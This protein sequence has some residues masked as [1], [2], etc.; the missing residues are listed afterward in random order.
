L[1]SPP[2]NGKQ[3]PKPE[4]M[5][6]TDSAVYKKEFSFLSDQEFSSFL[7]TVHI[8]DEL[9]EFLKSNKN[10]AWF[11]H[12]QYL[13]KRSLDPHSDIDADPV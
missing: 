8:A 7:Q 11:L 5:L 2:V 4:E 12:I 1:R 6:P 10:F 9:P 13:C 3:G